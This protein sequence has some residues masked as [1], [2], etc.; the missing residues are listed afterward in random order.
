MLRLLKCWVRS[1]PRR[2]RTRLS[3]GKVVRTGDSGRPGS[4]EGPVTVSQD[5]TTLLI[6]TPDQ[7]SDILSSEDPRVP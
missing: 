2:D 7:L 5:T 1:G 3:E 4:E 6:P